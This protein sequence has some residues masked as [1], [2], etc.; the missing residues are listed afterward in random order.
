MRTFFRR[1][2]S[3]IQYARPAKKKRMRYFNPAVAAVLVAILIAFTCTLIERRLMPIAIALAESRAR[4]IAN[5]TINNAINEYIM[6]NGIAYEDLY[7][8]KQDS[9]GYITALSSNTAEMNKI[10]A[11]LALK[12][13]EK[14]RNL[15]SGTLGI[16]IG[17]LTGY[18]LLSDVGPKV[19]ITLLTSGT[20]NLD[21]KN[22]FESAGLNQTK[23]AVYIQAVC[24]VTIILPGKRAKANV[25]TMIPVIETIIVGNVPN[26]FLG[27]FP[28][29]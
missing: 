5:E 25:D 3:H 27:S 11:A 19:P 1:I 2:R 4:N 13:Q 15:D 14:V 8:M 7:M 26:A 9:S 21:F 6:E 10:K 24:D 28:T 12:V 20:S 23:H 18:D 29:Q 16:P 22:S 17:A